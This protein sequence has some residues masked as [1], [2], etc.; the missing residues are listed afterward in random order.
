MTNVVNVVDTYIKCVYMWYLSWERE[1]DQEILN[2]NG[3]WCYDVCDYF[4]CG[5]WGMGGE[6]RCARGILKNGTLGGDVGL[7]NSHWKVN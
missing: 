5:N 2:E 7:S 1:G 4:K 3:S 6:G